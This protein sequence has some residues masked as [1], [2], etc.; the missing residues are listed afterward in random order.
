M[1]MKV[2][3]IKAKQ[4]TAGRKKEEMNIVECE[5]EKWVWREVRRLPRETRP[6]TTQQTKTLWESFL[7]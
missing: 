3:V 5:K 2:H 1:K 7:F 6:R 4:L